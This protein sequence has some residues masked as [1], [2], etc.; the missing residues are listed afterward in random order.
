MT[1][2]LLPRLLVVGVLAATLW[3]VLGLAGVS[4]AANPFEPDTVEVVADFPRTVGLYP[5][6]RVRVDG[7]DSGWVES[8]EPAVDGV[9]VT[10]KVNG[11]A[12]AADATATLRLKSMIGERYV[13]LGPSWNGKGPQLESGD[14]IPRERVRLPAEISDVLDNFTRL[15]E[16]VDKDALGRFVHQLATAVDGRQDDL[17]RMVDGLSDLGRV[18]AGR[19]DD[20]DTSIVNLQRVME[21]LA[22]RDDGMV[23]LMRSAATVSD[24]LLAQEGTLDASIEGVD[25]LLS[26]VE[27]LTR[28]QK[29]KLVTLLGGLDRVGDVLAKHEG[30]F[31]VVTRRLPSV[32][33]GYLRAVDHDGSRWYTINN[34]MG[35]MFL[36]Y[37]PTI[38][39]RGGP[40]SDREDN[41]VTPALD[42]SNSPAGKAVPDSVDGTKYTG[43][44]PLL[45]GQAFGFPGAQ[46][47]SDE[48]CED[49]R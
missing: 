18:V 2:R 26:Q 13:E 28:T 32:A 41:T 35:I 14:R 3:S 33:Y 23:R 31:E 4:L 45:P 8:V 12:L 43:D 22:S 38:N 49:S 19:A 5:K 16:D 37:G 30:D 25:G 7:I 29:E 36:P 39:G 47:C 11:V 21:T 27:T 24:T 46:F 44:G 40:G 1:S 34:P 10:L 17:A 42:H 48:A 6:S 20:I 15:A 9:E